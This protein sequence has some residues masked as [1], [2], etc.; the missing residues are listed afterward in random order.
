[1]GD[2]I[3]PFPF[4]TPQRVFSSGHGQQDA[5]CGVRV[6]GSHGPIRGSSNTCFGLLAYSESG[7]VLMSV[8][9]V[10]FATV[11]RPCS[12]ADVARSNSNLSCCVAL[13]S[14]SGHLTRRHEHARQRGHQRDSVPPSMHSPPHTACLTNCRQAAPSSLDNMMSSLT[15]SHSFRAGGFSVGETSVSTNQPAT[16]VTHVAAK[17]QGASARRTPKKRAIW[18]KYEMYSIAST[19]V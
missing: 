8:R 11:K 17:S 19:G 10:R 12:T 14:A 9:R 13:T 7:Y 4:R 6:G 5:A 3:E 18:R 15:H 2:G 16:I 1:V